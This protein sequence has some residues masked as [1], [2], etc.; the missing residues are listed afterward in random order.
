[1]ILHIDT[2]QSDQLSLSLTEN[3]QTLAEQHLPAH[4]NQAELLLPEIDKLLKA[5][6][7]QLTDI[8]KVIVQNGTGSFTSLRIG[9]ATANALAYALDIEVEDDQG[10]KL[11]ANNM[12]IVEPRYDREPNIT[13]KK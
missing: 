6:N 9:I 12:Q 7:K 8:K 11:L 4:Y 2:T 5:S 13:M 1:M 10:N 3:E